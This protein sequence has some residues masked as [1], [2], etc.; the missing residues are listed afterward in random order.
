MRV[1]CAPSHSHSPGIKTYAHAKN[2]VCD[3][4]YDSDA[5]HAQVVR[6]NA[7]LVSVCV[8]AEL[9][10]AAGRFAR[11]PSAEEIGRKVCRRGRRRRREA[12]VCMRLMRV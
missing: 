11:A 6:L 12:R 3:D 2:C 1:P 5:V 10:R 9:S 7:S 4:D 8:C